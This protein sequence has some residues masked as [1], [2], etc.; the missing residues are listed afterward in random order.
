MPVDLRP[1]LDLDREALDFIFE[2]AQI[3][4]WQWDPGCNGIAV[5]ERTMQACGLPSFVDLDTFLR[6]AIHPEDHNEFRCAIE[7]AIA[8]RMTSAR[9]RMLENDGQ[10]RAVDLRFKARRGDSGQATKVMIL[11]SNSPTENSDE[12]VRRAEQ[13]HAVME[14]L[15]I[16]TQAAGIWV[17]EFD[18]AK[19]TITWDQN[20]LVERTLKRHFGQELGSDLF[21]WVHPEDE[22]IGRAAMSAALREGKTDAAFRYRL[23][24]QDSS[25]RYIQA[26]A[27]TYAA[28]DGNPV[29]SLGVS[30]DVTREVEDAQRLEQ[31]AAELRVAQRR[32]ERASFSIQEGHW[33]IDWLARKHWASS[34]YYALLGYATGR[35]RVRDVREA[36][37]RSFIPT[38]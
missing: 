15:S 17:W 24:L 38:I 2:A 28:G 36:R 31:Q 14:R 11:S 26:Y 6:K 35:D 20:R 4:A 21:K 8:S 29:R 16:A 30:W 7:R 18:Y 23:K 25:V 19:Q 13:E 5:D 32:L 33:E 10:V 3:V 37:Q 9:V 12:L 1:S 22:N 27:R 34:N